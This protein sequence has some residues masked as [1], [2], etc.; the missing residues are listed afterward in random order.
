MANK[1]CREGA[2][3]VS[4]FYGVAH[5]HTLVNEESLVAE[6]AS[7]FMGVCKIVHAY[8]CNAAMLGAKV[9]V[10]SAGAQVLEPLQKAT[11]MSKAQ[12]SLAV[13]ISE[14]VYVYDATTHCVHSWILTCLHKRQA[15]RYVVRAFEVQAVCAPIAKIHLLVTMA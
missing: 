11:G 6:C 2:F 3:H 12:V 8:V 7:K 5:A 10:L 4:W 15:C 9:W 1:P 14:P 13:L